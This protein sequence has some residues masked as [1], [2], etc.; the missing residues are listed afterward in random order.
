[1]WLL[2]V[3]I[4]EKRAS[5]HCGSSSHLWKRLA[6]LTC[7]L[8]HRQYGGS[9]QALYHFQHLVK[10]VPGVSN[11]AADTLSSITCP[12]ILQARPTLILTAV[13]T[14]VHTP[15]DEQTGLRIFGMDRA[16][17]RYVG[18]S[19]RR[20]CHLTAYRVAA[21]RFHLHTGAQPLPLQ[22]QTVLRFVAYLAE[23]RLAHSTNSAY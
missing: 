18:N 2:G 11:V 16:V 5:A 9:C 14:H 13:F 4:S 23:G 3:D 8:P 21:G 22:Q 12:L 6:A 10:H 20:T 15:P 17:Q 1:M 7:Q 19:I